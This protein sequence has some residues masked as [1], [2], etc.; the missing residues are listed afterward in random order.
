MAIN[1]MAMLQMKERLAT[2]QKD[3]PRVFPFFN[4]LPS[5]SLEVSCMNDRAQS[6]D[7]VETPEAKGR[8]KLA[9]CAIVDG[10]RRTDVSLWCIDILVKCKGHKKP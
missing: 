7:N 10:H 5:D 3:H 4:M 8:R 2:F 9:F 1:P 6:G